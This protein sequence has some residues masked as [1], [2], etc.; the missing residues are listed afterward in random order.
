MLGPGVNKSACEP[1]KSLLSSPQPHG[2]HGN[3]PHWS[4]KP[5]VFGAPLLGASLKTWSAGCAV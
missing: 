5:D 3:E 1:F 2:S 4:S